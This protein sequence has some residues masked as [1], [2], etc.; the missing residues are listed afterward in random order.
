[1]F[2]AHEVAD[3]DNPEKNFTLTPH[4]LTL[5]NPNTRTAP[6]FRNRRDAEITTGI[7]RR[8]PVLINEGNQT[9]TPGTHASTS[10]S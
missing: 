6:T 1:M 10:C 8:V 4:D 2:F 5:F 3:I 9:E 7:Y